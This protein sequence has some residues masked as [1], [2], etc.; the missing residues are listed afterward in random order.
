MEW[1]IKNTININFV[2]KLLNHAFYGFE[3]GGQFEHMILVHLIFTKKLCFFLYI[4][5]I[6]K[7][8]YS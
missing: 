8:L 2:Y 5:K 6:M 1:A 7:L 3:K 4:I